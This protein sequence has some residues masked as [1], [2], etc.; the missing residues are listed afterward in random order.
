MQTNSRT[1]NQHTLISLVLLVRIVSL[2]GQGLASGLV[3]TAGVRHAETS[4]CKKVR[5]CA[6]E[7]V[8]VRH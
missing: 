7:E 4:N 2:W 8:F 1:G 5:A 6:T 3:E